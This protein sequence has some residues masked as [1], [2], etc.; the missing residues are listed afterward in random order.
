MTILIITKRASPIGPSRAV[1]PSQP[2]LQPADDDPETRNRPR[3]PIAPSC[4]PKPPAPR[5]SAQHPPRRASRRRAAGSGAGA[6]S[7]K[8]YVFGH[9]IWTWDFETLKIECLRAE[10][11]K[12]DCVAWRDPRTP[13]PGAPSLATLPSELPGGGS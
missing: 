2:P 9:G 7:R 11:V 8:G 3:D 5:H 4:P 6:P 10:I 13:F 1:V 12:T